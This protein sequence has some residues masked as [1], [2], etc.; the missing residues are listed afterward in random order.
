[1]RITGRTVFI[2]GA[3]SGIGLA[4]ALALQDAGSTVI[5]GGRRTALLDQITAEHPGLHAYPI[6]TA[7][8]ASITDVAARV[9]A[10]HPDLDVLITMAG[11]MR[12]ED[13]NRPE[14]FLSTAEEVVTTNLLGPI[15]LIAAFLDHLSSR[16]AAAIVTVSSGLAHVP[17][18]ATPTYNATKAA[19]HRLTESI[20]LQLAGTSVEVLEIVPPSVAT[21]LMPGQRESAIAMPL[22]DFVAET[23]ELLARPDATEILVDRVRFLREAEIRGDYPHVVATLNAA[24][25]HRADHSA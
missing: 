9:I 23:V 21:D 10:D 17:L 2:P 25:P 19:I 18:A 13:W 5:I 11:I 7:D 6:D 12:A 8:P 20:R 14:D 15:R 24:D 3:T 1:M 16:P 4:L 22:E